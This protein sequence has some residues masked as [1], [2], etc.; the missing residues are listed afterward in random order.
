MARSGAGGLA[1]QLRVL[2]I[3]SKDLNSDPSTHIVLKHSGSSRLG[4]QHL[5]LAPGATRY[6]V[7][8][9]MQVKYS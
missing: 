3:L 2:A 9:Y 1:Q 8:I 6:N 7:L 5:L 4:I